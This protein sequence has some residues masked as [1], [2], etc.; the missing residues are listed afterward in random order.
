MI[1]KPLFTA[2]IRAKVMLALMGTATCVLVLALSIVSA[3]Q[4]ISFRR[5]I[6]LQRI[7]HRIRSQDGNLV[8]PAVPA[9]VIERTS[10]DV[11]FN[12]G[13]TPLVRCLPK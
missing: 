12:P 9:A 2:S 4:Y 6:E 1:L 13:R 11:S 8:A 5:D 10:V 7:I 3:L